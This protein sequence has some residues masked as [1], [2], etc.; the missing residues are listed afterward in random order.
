MSL[1]LILMRH[2][3]SGWNDPMASDHDR[4]LTERGARD[5]RAIGTWLRHAGHVP[6]AVLSSD[7]MRTRETLQH[8]MA[9]LDLPDHAQYLPA[10]YNASADIIVRRVK[11]QITDTLLVCAHNPGI[12]LAAQHLVNAPPSHQRFDDYPTAAT[13]VIRFDAERWSDIRRGTCIDFVTPADLK[14]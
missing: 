9:S 10:L 14:Q 4:T 11:A 3:K 6:A 1:T 12:G 8:V 13:A 7:A 2:A 5:A